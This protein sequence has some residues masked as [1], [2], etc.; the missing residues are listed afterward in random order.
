MKSYISLP[1]LLLAL[2]FFFAGMSNPSYATTIDTTASWDEVQKIGLFGETWG[3]HYVG[4]GQTFSLNPGDDTALDSV[5]FHIN[6]SNDTD[7]VDFAFHV[8]EWSGSG[9]TGGPLFDSG[10]I[11]TTNNGGTGGF[12]AFT[13][14][15]GG[16]ELATGASYVWFTSVIPDGEWGTGGWGVIKAVD[17]WGETDPYLNGDMVVKG[18]GCCNQL[19]VWSNYDA[20]FT[21]ELSPA[22]VP[23]PSTFLLLGLGLVGLA[24]SR[25]RLGINT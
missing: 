15:T 22:S 18:S 1:G 9:I 10:S 25:R 4:F 11:S 24:L 3:Y 2:A 23:E 13:V 14:N 7:F 6:D 5:T 21:L 8:Y 16:I 20:A 19:S 12:E 17:S